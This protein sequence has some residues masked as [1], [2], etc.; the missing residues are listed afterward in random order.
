MAP[1][2]LQ[3]HRSPGGGPRH[4]KQR[5]GRCG[6]QVAEVWAVAKM[7]S[8]LCSCSFQPKECLL[9]RNHINSGWAKKVG[10]LIQIDQS[11]SPRIPPVVYSGC[12]PTTSTYP[13]VLWAILPL[14]WGFGDAGFWV[15]ESKDKVK[16]K[17][18]AK[19]LWQLWVAIV[20]SID[21]MEIFSIQLCSMKC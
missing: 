15:A 6:W 2:L 7:R 1:P 18:K 8:T 10:D 21:H 5:L 9:G 19:I 20:C 13:K 3:I 12:T 16:L 11:K 14:K 4:E 17:L